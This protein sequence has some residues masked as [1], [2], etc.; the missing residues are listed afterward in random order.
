[1]GPPAEGQILMRNLP[2]PTAWPFLP[3]LAAAASE[4]AGMRILEF[5]AANIY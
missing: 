5:F 3:E 1:M 4:R 2:D